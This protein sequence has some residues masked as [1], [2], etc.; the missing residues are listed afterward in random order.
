MKIAVDIDEVIASFLEG[1]LK[2]YNKKY[3]TDTS[4][5]EMSSYK[6]WE[7]LPITEE[8]TNS[9][10][11]EFYASEHFESVGLVKMAVE[12]I[13]KLS[14][15]HEIIFVTSRPVSVK[16]KTEN[17]IKKHFP[18]IPVKIFFSSDYYGG[19][20]TKS[21]ICDDQGVDFLVE[22]NKYYAFDCAKNGTCV[23]LLDKPWNKN[24]EEHTNLV[25]VNNWD[26]ILNKIK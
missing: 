26:E 24:H 6:F 19:E 13:K 22:D 14:A 20:L 23:F 12:S 2:V 21:Q 9:I 25:K 1:F 17:F 16:G 4:V 8:E 18:N 15:N 5:D 11:D 3:N 7:C 10:C